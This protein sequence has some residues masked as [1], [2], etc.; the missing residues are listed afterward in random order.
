MNRMTVRCDTQ[1]MAVVIDTVQA[2]P[3]GLFGGVEPGTG[4]WKKLIPSLKNQGLIGRR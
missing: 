2:V 4:S 3:S 1:Q